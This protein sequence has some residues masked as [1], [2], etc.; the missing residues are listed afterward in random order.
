MLKLN[1]NRVHLQRDTFFTLGGNSLSA[2]HFVSRCKA[3]G[4]RLAMADINRGN[5]LAGLA[6]LAVERAGDATMDLQPPEFTHGPF[7]LTPVQR[8]YF[9]W[10]LTDLHQW[11]LPLLMKLTTPRSLDE[12]RGVVTSLV[13]RHDMMRARFDQVDGEWQGRVLPIDEDP[14]VVNQCT[15]AAETDYWRVIDETHTMM[16]ITT[17]PIYLA[18]VMNYRDTQYFYLSLH[19]L[20]ADNTSMNILAQDVSTL[21]SGQSLSYKTLPYPIWS[22]NLDGLS[23]RVS[24]KPG[25]LPTEGELTL[26][27]SDVDPTPH[28]PFIQRDQLVISNL[29]ASTA[30]ALDQFGYCD[31]TAE[32]IILTGLLLAYTDVFNCDSIPLQYTSHGRNALGNSWDVSHTVGFFVNFCPIVLRRNEGNE[33]A[34]TVGGVQSVL[35]GVSDFAVKYMLSGQTMKSPIAYNFLG[36]HDIS[37]SAGTKGL[38]VIDIVASDEFQE[39]RVNMD[40]IPLIFLAKYTGECLPLMI[41]YESSRYSEKCMSAVMEKWEEGV[42]H[43][44]LQL[45]SQE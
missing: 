10:D 11:P 43:I 39:Q 21:L 6:K 36:K 27:P 14:V 33:L 1:P 28:S 31:I 5:T 24:L 15:L 4:I 38:E 41:S 7:S 30:F 35:R 23:D 44:L 8:L 37:D 32:D 13:S 2:M 25:Q 12:W 19:H 18:Y 9:S 22:Q 29:D 3:D 40:P 45:K 42:R 16:N 26:P 20:I 34:S 17:G